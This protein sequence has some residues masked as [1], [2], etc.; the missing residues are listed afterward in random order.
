VPMSTVASIIHKW[1]KFRTTR[2]LPRA[3]RPSKLSDRGKRALVREV[4]KNLMVTLSEL[5]RTSVERGEP[6]RRTTISAA[7]HQSGLYG[8]VARRKPLLSKRHMAARLE[9]VKMHLKDSQTMRNKILCSLFRL[10]V[11]R[12]SKTRRIDKACGAPGDLMLH[13]SVRTRFSSYC[14]QKLSLERES[15]PTSSYCT[16]VNKETE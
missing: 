15:A 8:R 1:K 4:T 2:T 10:A 7:I 9:F 3:G 11:F 13:I 16:T 6:S 12:R 14:C 5:Q